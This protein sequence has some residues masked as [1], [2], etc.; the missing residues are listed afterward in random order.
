MDPVFG[1]DAENVGVGCGFGAEKVG[2]RGDAVVEEFVVDEAE[3]FGGED[4]G[5]EVEV[6][7]FVVDEFEGEHG[8]SLSGMYHT[9]RL[10]LVHH[11]TK[12]MC[13]TEIDITL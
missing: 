8:G 13:G 3:F 2:W 12:L 4:V 9:A 10:P 7:T 1:V 6:V 5:A 11:W